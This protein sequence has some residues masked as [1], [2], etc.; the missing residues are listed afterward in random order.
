MIWS[1]IRHT[2][3]TESVAYL[4]LGLIAV[5]IAVLGIRVPASAL[6]LIFLTLLVIVYRLRYKRL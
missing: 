2:I 4:V 3:F 5:V 6:I 1:S